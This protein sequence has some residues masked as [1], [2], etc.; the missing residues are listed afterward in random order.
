MTFK[1]IT[2]YVGALAAAVAA[3]IWA[4]SPDPV[5]V[6]L[7]EVRLAPMEVTV[8]AEGMTRV[9]APYLVTAPISGTTTR[10]PVDVGDTVLRGETVVA[11]I[12]PAEPAFLDA[13]ARLQAEAAVVE[14]QAAVRLAEV[15]LERAEADLAFAET[16]LQR[17]RELAARGTIPQR[18]LEDSE[19][20][21]TNA[22]AALEA[23]R[24]ELT[25]HRASLARME[26]NL[27]GP[28]DILMPING[29]AG[30]CCVQIRAPQ[31]GT[32]LGVDNLSA[33]LVQAGA[34][35]LTIGD[36]SD[37]EVEVDLLSADAVRVSAGA[38]ARIE[39]WG[40]EGQI[41]AQVRRIDPAAFTRVSA[42]GIEEQRV[43]L[44]LDLLT[45][46]DERAGL[47]DQYRVHV[48]IVIWADDAVLQVPVSA[49][50]RHR[51]DWAVFVEDDGVAVLR[52]VE[53]GRMTETDAQVLSGLA[54]GEKVVMFPGD[55]V[56]EGSSIAQRPET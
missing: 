56:S 28:E 44:R 5:P 15:N 18:M 2:V 32:V 21:R 30:E 43:R 13:R 33:R 14:A 53:L 1:R 45:P 48:R 41:I 27:I 38:A 36:L 7:A 54:E 22:L 52:Q 24:S 6:D 55:R 9:R 34:P 12:Q 4:F 50:F 16:Q 26:A 51:G 35:L 10:S 8:S 37:L 11:V 19:Q 23:A 40:G 47:G 42:L 46:T 17:N 20:Q 39:R 25:L 31:T 49:L 29:V 3:L